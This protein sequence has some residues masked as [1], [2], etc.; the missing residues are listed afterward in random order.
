VPVPLTAINVTAD[1]S[2]QKVGAPYFDT[3]AVNSTLEETTRRNG[4]VVSVTTSTLAADG[5][6]LNVVV[7]DKEQGTTTRAVS[8]KQ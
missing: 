8:R 2:D 4:K 1:D 6:T 3:V 5:K 7:E